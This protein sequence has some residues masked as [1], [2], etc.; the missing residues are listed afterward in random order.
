MLAI[1]IENFDKVDS[2]ND[3]AM[4]Q[5]ESGKIVK[6]KILIA[7]LQTNGH[8]SKGRNFISDNDV[9]MYFT[10]IHFYNARDELSFITQKA[11]VAVYK[12]FKNIFNIELDIK[13][14]ND[15]YFNNK[16]VAGILCR[17]S[18]KHK[19]VIIGIGID[20]FYN[21]DL[22]NS[23]SD[24]AGYIFSNPDELILKL[25]ENCNLNINSNI[26]NDIH[27]SFYNKKIYASDDKEKWNPNYLASDIVNNLI[28]DMDY[29]GLPE[30][31]IEKNIIKDGRVYE[32][33]DLEC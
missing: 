3:Q 30:I 8:G 20:L 11:A 33:C 22:D 2:T 25:D 31:Y 26:Y 14:I 19:A 5:I 24:I 18:I 29:M 13:W 28:K 21:K 9:G 32:D 15:L 17:N 6:D 12:T 27:D 4:R 16:K 10:Y 1:D 23:I 7:R